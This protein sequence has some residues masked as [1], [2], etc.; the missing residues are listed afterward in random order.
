MI[1]QVVTNVAMS[2]VLNLAFSL[3]SFGLL[4]YYDVRL[5][6]LASGI[7]VVLVVVTSL[8]AVAQTRY[9]RQY[10]AIRSRNRG[11]VFQSDQR[12][13]ADP[14]GRRRGGSARCM[15]QEIHGAAPG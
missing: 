3:V 15:D 12:A 7:F 14:R 6:L 10:Y 5:A 9:Q 4:F 13:V 1:R 2:G 8:A 11:F